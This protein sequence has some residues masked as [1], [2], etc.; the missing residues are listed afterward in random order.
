MEIPPADAKD[1]TN[2]G[3]KLVKMLQTQ[4][5]KQEKRQLS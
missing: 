1:G 2:E 5:K 4:A 3:Q